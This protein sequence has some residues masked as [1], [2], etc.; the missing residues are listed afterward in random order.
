M[1]RRIQRQR[2]MPLAP[3]SA[4][5]R[6]LGDLVDDEPPRSGEPRS[7][8]ELRVVRGQLRRTAAAIAADD[9]HEVALLAGVL[10]DHLRDGGDVDG[11]ERELS[12]VLDELARFASED[13]RAAELEP[14]DDDDQVDDDDGGEQLVLFE[15]ETDDDGAQLGL[16]DE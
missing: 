15:D 4:V 6:V 1:T 16:F 2:V 9:W 12:G 3:S 7:A 5:P 10:R 14:D 8:R 13:V 11:A